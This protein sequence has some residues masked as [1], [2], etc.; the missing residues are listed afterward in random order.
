MRTFLI[1]HSHWSQRQTLH[2]WSGLVRCWGTDTWHWRPFARV[3]SKQHVT[4]LKKCEKPFWSKM[5]FVWV[6]RPRWPANSSTGIHDST[7]TRP[8]CKH[9]VNHPTHAECSHYNACP[10]NTLNCFY[11]GVDLSITKIQQSLIIQWNQGCHII[12]DVT[13]DKIEHHML[14]THCI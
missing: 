10:D 7:Q 12:V 4:T 14:Y 8:K 9:R 1:R 6:A 5:A 13:L 11:D 3:T 2:D